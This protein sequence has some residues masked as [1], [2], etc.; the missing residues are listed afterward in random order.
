MLNE[1]Y[2]QFKSGT[3]IRG[4]ATEGVKGQPVNLTG[5]VIEKMADGFVLWLAG[6][7][8]KKP[9]DLKISVGRDSRVSGPHIMELTAERFRRAGAEVLRCGLAS[10][11]S[12]FMTTVDLGCDGALQ[13]TAS[14]HPFNRNGLKFF[15]RGGGLEGSDIEDILT[16][17]QEDKHP[18]EKD[19]GSIADVDYMSDYA[20]GMCEKIK[21]EVNAEDYDKPLKGFKIVVDA[22]NGAGGFY[23][24]KVLAVLGA[25]TEGSRYLDPDGMFPNHVPNPED[26]A[27][28]ASISEAVRENNADLGVIFDTDVDRG[29]AVDSKGNEINR[30]RLVAV[31]AAIALEGNDGGTVVTDS[32]TSSGLKTFIEEKLGGRHYRYR[33]GYKNVIDK[34]LELNAQGINCP[35]AIETSGHAAMRENYFLDDGAYLCTKIIIKAAQMRR[36]GKELDELTADLREPLESREIRYKITEKDFRACG[37]KIIA[38]LTAYAESQPGWQLA[39][40]NREGVRVSFDKNGG[41]GWFLLRLSVHDPIMPL[42]IESDSEGGVEIILG[43]LQEFLKTTSGLQL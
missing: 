16:F 25:D 34:A 15:T 30:N 24:E 36:E 6:K 33:R 35:L 12:M 20:K 39:D 4:V 10:T 38:D 41:D 23:A 28:M 22:G 7:T 2:R 14:H 37:E 3:D 8:S 42:N 5:D 40:D 9:C 19:G 43:K 11:P 31:A 27:A 13:I 17:A 32:I 1:F 26:A 21:R 29:G 18:E